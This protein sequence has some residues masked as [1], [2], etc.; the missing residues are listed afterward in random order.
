MVSEKLFFAGK[1]NGNKVPKLLSEFGLQSQQFATEDDVSP[2][3][4]MIDF[5]PARNRWQELRSS[6]E[7]FI[8]TTLTAAE[9]QDESARSASV[10]KAEEGRLALTYSPHFHSGSLT[11]ADDKS[12][13][14]VNA[15]RTSESFRRRALKSRA[16]EYTDRS[17]E[18][19]NT[20]EERFQ[21]SRFKARRHR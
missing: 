18:L 19:A 12:T 16:L 9:Q 5:A 4:P 11:F 10:N 2:F 13:V 14:A 17:H 21:P 1:R 15:A 8:R 7:S 3:S 20:G 6:S